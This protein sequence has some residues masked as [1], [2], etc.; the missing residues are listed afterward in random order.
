MKLRQYYL[1]KLAEE[2]VEVSQRALKQAQF[3]ASEVQP[4]QLKT[5][6]ERLFEEI[7]DLATLACVL[8]A[9]DEIPTVPEIIRLEMKV[10]KME[11]LE[12]YLKYSRELGHVD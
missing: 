10:K 1:T 8:Q 6:A 7:I 12:K 11:K 5:N 4:G 9:I 3:G 2:A